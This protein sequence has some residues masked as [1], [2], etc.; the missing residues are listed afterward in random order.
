M[1]FSRRYDMEPC[2]AYKEAD[3]LAMSE[4]RHAGLLGLAPGL[5]PYSN[6]NRSLAETWEECRA[7]AAE[8]IR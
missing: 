2:A 6:G 3:E 4:G 7:E 8:K 1:T 5:N